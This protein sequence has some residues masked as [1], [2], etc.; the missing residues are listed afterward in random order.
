M[1][2]HG[3]TL[4]RIP[5]LLL[6]GWGVKEA[7]SF[8]LSRPQFPL[9]YTATVGLIYLCSPVNRR[10]VGFYGGVPSVRLWGQGW[11]RSV[12]LPQRFALHLRT[13]CSLRTYQCTRPSPSSQSVDLD[14]L[15]FDC[16]TRTASGGWLNFPKGPEPSLS[17]CEKKRMSLVFCVF[18][19]L[20]WQSAQAKC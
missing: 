10:D 11:G 19:L 18:P 2:T 15:P 1:Q 4:R 13:L 6:T 20:G 8:P 12:S 17:S 9:Q 3:P 7:R 14:Q 16:A 5:V